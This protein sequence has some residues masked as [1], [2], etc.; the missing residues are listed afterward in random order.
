MRDLN[1][2]ECHIFVIIIAVEKFVLA[3][4]TRC[5]YQKISKNTFSYQR[6]HV[7]SLV[8]ISFDFEINGCQLWPKIRR[9]HPGI[10]NI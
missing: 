1:R 5:R 7:L 4:L 3:F 2:I 9:F 10:P 6:W 8:R